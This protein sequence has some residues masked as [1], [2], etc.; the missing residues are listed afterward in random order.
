MNI[1]IYT[2]ASITFTSTVITNGA[3]GRF[4]DLPK[5]RNLKYYKLTKKI[6]LFCR[7]FK[8]YREYIFWNKIILR[9]NVPKGF[10]WGINLWVELK[11]VL[12]SRF[13]EKEMLSLGRYLI[14]DP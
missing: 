5:D 4:F 14:A 11:T 13:I 8:I 3:S 10:L 12:P 9:V 7:I 1:F 6:Q 2:K